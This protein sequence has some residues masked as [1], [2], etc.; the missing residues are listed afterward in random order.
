MAK[1]RE[2]KVVVEFTDGYRERYTKALLD[3]YSKRPGGLDALL[4]SHVPGGTEP[5]D[6]TPDGVAVPA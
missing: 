4:Q 5:T 6:N 2:I 1:Q 3:V